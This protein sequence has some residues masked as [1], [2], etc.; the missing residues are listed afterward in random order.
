MHDHSS[1]K[2]PPQK[3]DYTEWASRLTHRAHEKAQ[4]ELAEKAQY[5]KVNR[6]AELRAG[7]GEREP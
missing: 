6:A 7:S 2:S 3:F 1:H 4:S 5:L